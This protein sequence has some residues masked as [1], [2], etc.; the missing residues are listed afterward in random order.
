MQIERV[1]VAG[2]SGATP[3]GGWAIELRPDDVVHTLVTVHTDTGLTGVGSAYSDDRLVRAA[4]EVLSPLLIGECALEPERVSEKLHQHTFWLGRGGTL[5]H[6]ISG[7]DM[8]L[9]DIL[10]KACDQPVGRLLGGRYRDRVRPYASLLMDEPAVL[11][12]HLAA[13]VAQGFSA[14]KIGWGPFGRR[15]HRLDEAMVRS[16]REAIGPDALL[17]VDAGA[18]DGFWPHGYT[19]ALRTAAML[20]A[21]DVEW[22]EEPLAPDDL[23]GYA[24]LRRHTTVKIAGGEVLTRRQ[25]FLPWLEA[26]ALDIVQPDVTKVGGISEQRRIARAAEDHG[27]AFVGHGWNTAVGLAADLQVA[28]AL[29]HT[30][31]VEYKTGS[32]YVDDLSVEGFALD[33]DGMLAVPTRPGLGVTLDPDALARY[34][35]TVEVTA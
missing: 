15:S 22:F 21:Y 10:G 13:L 3:A 4:I 16:A 14:Y 2:L 5:T 9:W 18:S 29:P 27:V 31:L 34:A 1:S 23:H 24:E 30:E 32:A 19:W 28:S 26:R 6:A 7:I 12:D 25:A 17:M 11:A 20:A 35:R 8:A 33:D